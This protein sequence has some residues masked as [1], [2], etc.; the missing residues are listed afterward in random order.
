MLNLASSAR[1]F[2]AD[3]LPAAQQTSADWTGDPGAA[4]AYEGLRARWA[5]R[6]LVATG[7]PVANNWGP[8]TDRGLYGSA[9][10]GMLGAIVG[11]TDDPAVLSLDCL[12]TDFIRAPAYPTRLIYNPHSTPRRVRVAF[13]GGGRR[14]L[15]DAVSHRFIMRGVGA[16]ARI[17]VAADRAVVLVSCPAGGR[18]TRRGRTRFVGGVAVDYWLGESSSGGGSS[19]V[20]ERRSI[21]ASP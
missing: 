20:G 5:G 11:R 12:A 3:Q 17:K 4:I 18:V 19:V 15:Y 9:Y 8:K 1:L 6:A 13:G 7:D 16:T 2:Y 10:C 14:D 21:T